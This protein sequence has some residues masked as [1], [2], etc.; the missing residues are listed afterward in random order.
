[1][2]ELIIGI[3]LVAGLLVI[4]R[5]RK[6]KKDERKEVEADA[7]DDTGLPLPPPPTGGDPH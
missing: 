5:I 2:K 1:M 7:P 4:L 6:N 3:V